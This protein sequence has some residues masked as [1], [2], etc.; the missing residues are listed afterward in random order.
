M[1]K[2]DNK[3][4]EKDGKHLEKTKYVVGKRVVKLPV[5]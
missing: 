3:Q 4:R 5:R 1:K 2:K